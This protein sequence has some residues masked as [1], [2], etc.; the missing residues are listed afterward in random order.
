MNARLRHQKSAPRR[1][2]YPQNF[3]K[4]NYTIRSGACDGAFIN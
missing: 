3:Y 1:H 4:F 2:A